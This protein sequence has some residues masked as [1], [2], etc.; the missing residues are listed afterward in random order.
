MDVADQSVDLTGH[1]LGDAAAVRQPL[2]YLAVQTQDILAHHEHAAL[3]FAERDQT[4]F[5]IGH[6]VG[7]HRVASGQLAGLKRFG[8]NPKNVMRTLEALLQNQQTV[9]V[10]GF[11][12][13]S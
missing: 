8:R 9:G 10:I 3:A 4:L 12:N 11:G 13:R 5:D 7:E 1:R 2:L 6:I